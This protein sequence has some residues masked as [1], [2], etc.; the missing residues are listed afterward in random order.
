MVLICGEGR[1]LS[2]LVGCDVVEYGL[3]RYGK[4]RIVS[5]WQGSGRVRPSVVR[6]AGRDKV[7]YG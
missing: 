3:M 1:A 2:Y 7:R 5:L 4:V 6:A